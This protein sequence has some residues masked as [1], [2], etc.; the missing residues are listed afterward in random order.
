[1]LALLAVLAGG[2]ANGD[3]AGDHQPEGPTT[4]GT[5]A[6]S[7]APPPP[8][9]A[10]E[11]AVFTIRPWFVTDAGL[12]QGE[13]RLVQGPDVLASTLEQLLAGP[14]DTDRFFGLD[15]GISSRVRLRSAT[16][17]GDTVV[18]DFDRAFET[19]DTQPQVAQV[20]W[21]LTELR[22][23]AKVKFLIDGEDNGA[24]GVRPMGRNDTR[25]QPAS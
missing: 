11:G 20:V 23:V 12:V 13:E 10:P 25:V 19:A 18:V 3:R 17:D 5:A 9:V 16:V 21:T 15:T 2:C 7:T 1:M 14:T 4:T 22:G 8:V 24:T 6:P